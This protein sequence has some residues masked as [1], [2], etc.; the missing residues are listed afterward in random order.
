MIRRLF[1]SKDNTRALPELLPV[2]AQ[3]P[4]FTLPATTGDKVSLQQM[5]GRP[6]V[7]AF[8]PAD[9]TPTCS[10]Q[11]A[12]YNESLHL[13]AEYDAQLV[14][15][16]TDSLASHEAFAASLGLG[17][18]LLADD[19]PAGAVA[20]AYNVYDERDGIAERAL[21]VL[22]ED[23]IVRWRQV[24]PRG[25]NPGAHGILHALDELT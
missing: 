2:G 11:L 16:S 20:R 24:G 4:D 18:P 15:L 7:L 8:Y 1:K 17:F 3:A 6:V 21:Y 23:G 5:R 13:F 14:A 22:D 25:E 9:A 19:E 12:L 10:N